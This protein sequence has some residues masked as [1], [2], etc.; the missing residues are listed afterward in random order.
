MYLQVYNPLQQADTSLQGGTTQ[1]QGGYNPQTVAGP[2]MTELKAPTV[3]PVAPKTASTAPVSLRGPS[4]ATQSA[5]TDLSGSYA[6]VNG[7]V[8]DKATSQG[9]DLNAFKQKTGIQ[10]PNWSA[11]K[12]DTAW[13]PQTQTQTAP[14]QT[15]VD[16]YSQ[17]FHQ[18]GQAGVSTSD[19]SSLVGLTAEEKNAIYQ[20]LGVDTLSQQ[21]Y[22]TP[23]KNTQQ[24]YTDA[25]A[26]AG[27]ADI[28]AKFQTLQEQINSRHADLVKATGQIN[29]NPWLSE[30]SRVGRIRT[31]NEAAQAEISNLTTQAQQVADLYNQGLSE[32]NQVV[33]NTSADISKN[34]QTRAEQLKYLIAQADKEIAS[35]QQSKI[36]RY[37][38]EYLKGKSSASTP[39]YE[40]LSQGQTLIDPTTGKVI[41]SA[42]KTY[43]PSSS[44]ST[45][46][47]T[48]GDNPQLYAGLSSPTATAVR[49]K[50]SAFKSEPVIQNFAV[51]QDG[52]NF[53]NSISNTTKNPA[54]DQA[55]IYSLAK[56]LDPNS[57]VR[58]GEYATAQ[59]YSQSW[60]NAFGKEV[61]QAINGT[62]FLSETARQNIK[63][64]IQQKYQSS[65]Q[66][67]E[68]LYNQYI[69]NLNTLTGRDDGA[70]FLQNYSTA[71]TSSGT[72]SGSVQDV[73]NKW[74]P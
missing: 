25:Y 17:L 48:T 47:S 11:L 16:P 36:A 43:A 49:A 28:K 41:Y 4:V 31:L 39:K 63:K 22:A 50:V 60:I 14:A 71:S 45:S 34:E 30:A 55:L 54:D 26:S 64:T 61:S 18:A 24:I 58:E 6:L 33:Q 38:P 53:A 13:T 21:I 69:T 9:L 65:K 73:I 35:A 51:V 68:N 70:S 37:F 29:E 66:S 74:V 40:T 8:Y 19:L 27:L 67:Y 12:F 62:G 59:K 2:S 10:N 56:A 44:G 46:V 7:T 20:K 57:V 5:I 42:P 1:L 32:V 52:Y 23:S 3:A 72:S 15:Q